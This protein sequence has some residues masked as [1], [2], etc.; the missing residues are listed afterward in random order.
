MNKNEFKKELE[1]Y[2]LTVNSFLDLRDAWYRLD[3]SEQ[4][5]LLKEEE[6]DE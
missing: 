1:K 2:G 4:L 3:A 5:E 6:E